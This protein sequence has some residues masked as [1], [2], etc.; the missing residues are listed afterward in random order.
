MVEVALIIMVVL[1][2]HAVGVADEHGARLVVQ[3]VLVV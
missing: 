2:L 3:L 1:G